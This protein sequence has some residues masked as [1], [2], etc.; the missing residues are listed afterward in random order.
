MR[1]HKDECTKHPRQSNAPEHTGIAHFSEV[2]VHEQ[3]VIDDAQQ[4]QHQTSAQYLAI[5]GALPFATAALLSQREGERDAGNEEEQGEDGVHEMQPVP[6]HMV[7]LIAQSLG[8]TTG[9]ERGKTG[10]QPCTTHD[11]EH[12]EATQ[13][14]ER[15]QS[16]LES[17]LLVVVIFHIL[18]D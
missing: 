7:H 18:F 5:D 3:A 15:L 16:S 14:V 10:E 2:Q 8:E 4:H 9:E 12:V 6:L 17:M 1:I 11:K 13:C